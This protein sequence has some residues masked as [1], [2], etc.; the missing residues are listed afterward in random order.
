[1]WSEY[2]PFFKKG[3]IFDWPKTESVIQFNSAVYCDII[4]LINAINQNVK[5]H[6]SAI[7]EQIGHIFGT[8]TY[9]HIEFW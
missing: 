8:H 9:M 5:R 7:S 6:A 1:M 4:K 2:I 3:H